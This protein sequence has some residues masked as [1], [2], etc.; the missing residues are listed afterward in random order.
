M[1]ITEFVKLKKFPECKVGGTRED[2]WERKAEEHF[3]KEEWER[4]KKEMKRLEEG[5]IVE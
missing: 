4:Q 2:Y 3:G 1:P 5:E